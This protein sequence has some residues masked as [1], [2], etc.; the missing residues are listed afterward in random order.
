MTDL[1]LMSYYL[2]LEV[3]HMKEGIFLSQAGMQKKFNLLDCNPVNTPM[4]TNLNLSKFEDEEK[5]NQTLFKS[6]VGSLRYLTCSRPDI[7][8]AVGVISRLMEAPTSSHMK[9]AKRIFHYLKG[10]LDFG[11]FYSR[12]NDFTLKGFCDSDYA[13]DID[14][15]KSTTA[16]VFFMGDCAISWC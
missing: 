16:F 9:A 5:V 13:G 14:N 3:K 1:G 4:E 7:L 12:S 2:G 8:F 15:W 11:K 10:T 6:L